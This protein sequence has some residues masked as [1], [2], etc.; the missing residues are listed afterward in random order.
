MDGPSQ[1]CTC[2]KGTKR[3][4]QYKRLAKVL[5]G[6]SAKYMRRFYLTV[7]IPRMMYTGDL[8]LVPESS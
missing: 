6:M 3:V 4:L 7:A 8:F 2:T 5:G 1:S